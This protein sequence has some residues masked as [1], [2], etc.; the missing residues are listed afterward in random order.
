MNFYSWLETGKLDQ[1]NALKATLYLNFK[2][3]HE[4]GVKLSNQVLKNYFIN[5]IRL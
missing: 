2:L 5:I 3:L 1:V 4:L